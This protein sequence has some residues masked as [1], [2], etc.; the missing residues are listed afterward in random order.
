M[1]SE[2]ERERERERESVCVCVCVCELATYYPPHAGALNSERERERKGERGM[3][4][5]SVLPANSE[6]L[7]FR[8]PLRRGIADI[9]TSW[10]KGTSPVQT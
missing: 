9:S 6:K 4:K 7:A 3:S 2:Q 5:S 8:T 1:K 10:H